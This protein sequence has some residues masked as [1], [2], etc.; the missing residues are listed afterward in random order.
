MGIVTCS[1]T[2]VGKDLKSRAALRLAPSDSNL[3]EVAQWADK[4]RM[5]SDIRTLLTSRADTDDD[6]NDNGDDNDGP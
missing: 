2:D 5:L 6:D 4:Q 1:L 3:T